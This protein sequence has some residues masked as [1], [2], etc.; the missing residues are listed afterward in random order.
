[1]MPRALFFSCFLFAQ[2]MGCHDPSSDAPYITALREERM[3][4]HYHPVSASHDNLSIGKIGRNLKLRASGISIKI[5]PR[6]DP[7]RVLIRKSGCIIG[8]IA[9]HANTISFIPNPSASSP[10]TTAPPLDFRCLP[11][12][13]AMMNSGDTTAE[14]DI[15]PHAIS[16]PAFV[17]RPLPAAHRYI[18]S[19]TSANSQA[20]H[21]HP[22]ESPFSLLGTAVFNSAAFPLAT[23]AALA[24]YLTIFHVGCADNA[25][26]I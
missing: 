20:C 18:L 2:L 24:W 15:A 26:V 14:F 9:Q 12:S 10:D 21:G 23:R 4:H 25:T 22:L 7:N 6:R 13:R 19:P 3:T 1:M 17:V 16:T 5:S 11:G 8:S